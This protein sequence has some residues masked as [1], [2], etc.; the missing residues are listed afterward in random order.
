[1][2]KFFLL[3][4][5]L[6]A[7]LIT[8][9][10][11][12][13]TVNATRVTVRDSL[14][15]SDRWIKAVNNDNS[16]HNTSTNT[17]ATDASLKS[18]IDTKFINLP[19]QE[20]ILVESIFNNGFWETYDFNR[21]DSVKFNIISADSISTPVTLQL[22]AGNRILVKGKPPFSI[23][24]TY[25]NRTPGTVL[26]FEYTN[27]PSTIFTEP[28]F[29]SSGSS[30]DFRQN[31]VR[32]NIGEREI[33]FGDTLNVQ[34][35]GFRHELGLIFGLRDS[36]ERPRDTL[37]KPHFELVNETDDYTLHFHGQVVP[38]QK[39]ISYSN[40]IEVQRSGAVNSYIG[41][42]GLFLLKDA[43]A[44]S[45]DNQRPVKLAVYKNGVYV[46]NMDNSDEWPEFTYDAT[47]KDLRIILSYASPQ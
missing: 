34:A 38:P 28:S 47:L 41:R 4:G 29:M 36:L 11:A 40:K 8:R 5:L 16:L 9:S 45:F 33:Y 35:G 2:K 14:R 26:F 22:Y 23:S 19:R 39:S 27:F 42:R 18:Y 31:S 46:T 1:M 24:S 32:Y 20:E 10:Y 17:I 15:L 37:I 43:T 3:S 6:Y 12:Q 25:I 13:S 30:E 7:L 21:R 44:V